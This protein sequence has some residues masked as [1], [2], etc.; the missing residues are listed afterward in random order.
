MF[1]AEVFDT[2]IN[3]SPE[4][5][6]IE[7]QKNVQNFENVQ[8]NIIDGKVFKKLSEATQSQTTSYITSEQPDNYNLFAD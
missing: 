1:P 4:E 3:V 5:M 2:F 8:L 7:L 6:K